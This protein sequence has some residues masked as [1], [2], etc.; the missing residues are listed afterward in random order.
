ML[1][2]VAVAVGE[3][4]AFELGVVSEVF[5]L[6][7]TADGLPGFDFAVCAID[8][9]P[10]RTTSGFLVDTPHGVER[11]E[12]AD[13]IVIPGWQDHDRPPPEPLVTALRRA[14]RR[15]ARVMSV[16][17]GAFVLA[18][19][20][21]LDGRRA[22]THW[23]YADELRRRHPRVAVDQQVLYIDEGPVLTSAG[24]AAGIDLCL[25]ILRREFG[26]GVANAIARRMVVPAHRDGGQAQ[27]VETPVPERRCSGDIAALLD[28]M[29]RHL[30]EPLT[31]D[32]LASRSHMSARTFARRFHAATGTAPHRWLVSRRC[33]L[34]EQLLED[35]DLAVEE[36]ARAA[37]F[38]D[39]STLRGHFVRRRGT[40]PQRYRQVFRERAS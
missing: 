13:L 20:R 33:E 30:A 4:A 38:G 8:P 14:I 25:H 16:C 18:A 31:V 35:T 6:D 21:L 32:Q 1:R 17:S 26:S 39:A 34:A 3:G 2:D 9:P 40:A 11:L 36:I 23:R 12:T 7:R 19:A 28:W 22:A 37:G 29:Q 27:F 15:G 10:L 24:T 5:G